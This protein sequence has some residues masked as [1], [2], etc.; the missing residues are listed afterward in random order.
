MF[1]FRYITLY[2]TLDCDHHRRKLV[3]CVCVFFLALFPASFRPSP[4]LNPVQSVLQA[5]RYIGYLLRYQFIVALCNLHTSRSFPTQTQNNSS[6]REVCMMYRQSILQ[7]FFLFFVFLSSVP[8]FLFSHCL[9][10]CVCV[11]S[12]LNYNERQTQQ[13]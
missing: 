1:L 12:L 8:K 6:G 13:P 3:V 2:V 11:C 5:I 10:V 7:R 4:F 9:C